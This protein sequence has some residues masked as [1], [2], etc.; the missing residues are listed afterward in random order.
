MKDGRGPSLDIWNA[1]PRGI[2]RETTSQSSCAHCIDNSKKQSTLI[3]EVVY[4][5]SAN[6]PEGKF[7][8]GFII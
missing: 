2:Q 7:S 5:M 6:I 3:T 1:Q 8:L 4:T